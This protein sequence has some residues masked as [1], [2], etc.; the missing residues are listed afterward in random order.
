[1]KTLFYIHFNEQELLDH[2]EPLK[3]AG[4][5]VAYHFTEGKAADFGDPLPDVFI[6]SLDRVPSHAKA[7]AQWI[8]QAK[9]RQH[10]PIVFVGG[11][12]EKV[13]PLQELFPKAHFCESKK[14]LTLLR[15]LP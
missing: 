8:W 14:L 9:K 1:M 3:K 4:Y 11:K 7:Y 5:E 15:S 10:I 13:E 6:L 12:A 2:I